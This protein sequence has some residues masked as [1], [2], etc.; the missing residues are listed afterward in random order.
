MRLWH[1]RLYQ[2]ASY[3]FTPAYQSD[4]AAFA[5]VRD[6]VISPLARV[7]PMPALLAMLVAG[8]LGAPFS[9]LR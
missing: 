1:V 7:P 2:S 3:L 8:E 4:S 9:A 5:W 6:F